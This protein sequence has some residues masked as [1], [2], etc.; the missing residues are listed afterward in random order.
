M[1][2]D[3]PLEI[4][5]SLSEGIITINKEFKITFI[6][7]AAERIIGLKKDEIFGMVCKSVLCS[8]SCQTACPIRR[9]LETGNSLFNF[10]NKIRNSDNEE[11]D[12]KLNATV[13]HDENSKPL[14]AVISFVDISQ[15][16]NIDNIL[17]ESS[18]F[19]GIVGTSKQMREIYKLITEISDSDVPVLIQGE[20]GTGKELIANA[21]Q[22]ISRR[23]RNPFLK[24]NCAVFSQELLASE[25]FGHVKGSFTGADRNRS[26]RFELAN[27]GTMFLDEISEMPLQMQTHLLRILQDGT[28]ERVGDSITR[29][30]DVRIIAA[31]N[32]DIEKAIHDKA[33]REDLFFR[34]NVVT[35]NLP[36]LRERRD[37]ISLLVNHFIKKFSIIYNKQI[38][39]IE[40]EALNLLT[41]Y[42]WPGN[43][44]QLE[45]AIEYAFVRSHENINICSCVLPEFLRTTVD[46]IHNEHHIQH[47]EYIP[48]EKLIKLLDKNGWNQSKVADELGVNRTTI[49][50]KI[51][52][53]DLAVK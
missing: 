38:V 4:L 40:K 45:N 9:I 13:L 32:I 25:L 1:A 35:I 22:T 20:T 21:I 39:G 51:K 48:V 8:N 31:T 36:P 12:V 50:R 46:C 2:K 52:E 15:M 33:F 16:Q 6:N 11:I 37:D 53:F 34:I 7:L 43:I 47:H 5:D 14:G 28:F 41:N 23:K 24:I 17:N 27:T 30:T 26:G 29:N 18:N 19:H 49:W 42:S 10:K 3:L 44:R